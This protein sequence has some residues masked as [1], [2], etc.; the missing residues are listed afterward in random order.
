MPCSTMSSPSSRWRNEREFKDEGSDPSMWGPATK[1]LIGTLLG[2]LWQAKMAEVFDLPDIFGATLG[3]G[4]HS[5]PT[6]GYL[7]VHTDFNRHPTSRLYRRINCLV[8]L[9]RGWRPEWGGVLELDA[10]AVEPLFNR[11]AIFAT[12]DVSWHGH[13]QPWAGPAPRRSG[14][15]YYYSSE[16]PPGYGCEH[17]TRWR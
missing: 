4:Y 15:V 14:A 17:D 7:A 11:T 9:N 10:V 3:G 2:D 13:P 6:G 16:P 5:I 1:D 8:F 12:S